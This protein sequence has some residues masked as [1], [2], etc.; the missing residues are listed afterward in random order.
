MAWDEHATGEDSYKGDRPGSMHGPTIVRNPMHDTGSDTAAEIGA[1]QLHRELG[2][3]G[4]HLILGV[5]RMDY[6][7]GIVERLLAV[8]HLLDD[9]PWYLEKI[10]F[11]QI[12]APSRTHIPSYVALRNQVHETVERINRRFETS[13]WKPVILIER[14]CSHKEV[15]RYYRAA[16]ICVVTSLH[17]GMNLVAKEYPAA[18]KDGDGVLILSRFT[19]AAQELRDALLV[20]PYDIVQVGEAIRTG[21]EM[22]QGERRLRMERL[23]HQV[24]EYNVYRW[25]SNVLTDVCAVRLES[26]AAGYP[27]S[28][29]H[30]KLA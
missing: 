27:P 7:K 6:T 4:Q 3:E 2:I 19:G 29:T 18:R 21:L 16:E 15:E 1:G 9:H 17:D 23:R 10:T 11:A 12:A 8:E 30:R 20:N 26:D 22:S 14:Q 5:D 24:K 13:K 25:A 28:E